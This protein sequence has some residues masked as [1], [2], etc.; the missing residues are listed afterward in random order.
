MREFKTVLHYNYYL[1]LKYG[2]FFF[3]INH[4][5]L[6]SVYTRDQ[7]VAKIIFQKFSVRN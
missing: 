4:I 1:N 5:I 3:I 7:I 2:C 6:L